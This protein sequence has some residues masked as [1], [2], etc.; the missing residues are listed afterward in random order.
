VQFETWTPFFEVAIVITAIQFCVGSILEPR[1]MGS[2][3]N[4]SPLILLL[5][6][7]LLG[8]IWGIPGMFLCVPITVIIVIIC[9]Y[10]PQTRPLA[11]I[12]PATAVYQPVPM[13]R[14]PVIDTLRRHW[15]TLSLL[16]VVVLAFCGLGLPALGVVVPVGIWIIFLAQGMVSRRGSAQV[17]TK[18]ARNA[19]FSS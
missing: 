19:A 5:S 15:F 6:L 10:F 3:L 12:S 2:K 16:G 13:W 18:L 7:A 9:S 14:P 11:V 8:S 17:R 1:L 4:L